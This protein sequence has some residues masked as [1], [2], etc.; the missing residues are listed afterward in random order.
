MV[1]ASSSSL[2][3]LA[4]NMMLFPERGSIRAQGAPARNGGSKVGAG[5]VKANQ[6]EYEV[7][8]EAQKRAAAERELL[9]VMIRGRSRPP[10]MS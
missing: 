4:S 1:T 8:C 5:S 7:W 10:W 3:I 6:L 2:P 9:Q